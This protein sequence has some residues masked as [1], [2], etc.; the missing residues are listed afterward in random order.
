MHICIYTAHIHTY[1]HTHPHMHPHMHLKFST[2]THARTQYAHIHTHT[3]THT[4]SYTHTHN[5]HIWQEKFCYALVTAS[6]APPILHWCEY[7]GDLP[8]VAS[9]SLAFVGFN[10]QQ[11][12]SFICVL[13]LL[14]IAI[15]IH[16]IHTDAHTHTHT[17]TLTHV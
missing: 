16:T 12:R 2:C 13:N 9:P 8:S 7:W 15:R 17:C 5:T 6:L 11:N 4:H 1:T 10:C 14:F 3:H